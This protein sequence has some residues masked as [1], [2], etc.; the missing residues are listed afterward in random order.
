MVAP[1]YHISDIS[2]AIADSTELK[3]REF[4]IMLHRAA[5]D[6]SSLEGIGCGPWSQIADWL[7]THLK[8]N[9]QVKI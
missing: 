7:D 2:K 3:I 6:G 1:E 9:L 4:L 5:R 8:A